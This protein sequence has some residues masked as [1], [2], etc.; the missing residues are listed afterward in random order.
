MKAMDAQTLTTAIGQTQIALRC[1]DKLLEH[2]C[3]VVAKGGS[4]S[5]AQSDLAASTMKTVEKLE[6]ELE[7]LAQSLGELGP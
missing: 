3:A 5:T 1:C 2:L 4:L 7:A 6:S